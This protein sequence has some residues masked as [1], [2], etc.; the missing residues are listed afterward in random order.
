MLETYDAF[1]PNSQTATLETVKKPM[2][3]KPDIVINKSQRQ[4]QQVLKGNT[5]ILMQGALA[6]N[7]SPLPPSMRWGADANRF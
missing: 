2:I 6:S 4:A 3:N 1:A 5:G 7:G